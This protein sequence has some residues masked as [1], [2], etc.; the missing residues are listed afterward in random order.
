M[1]AVSSID[2]EEARLQLS[3][4]FLRWWDQAELIDRLRIENKPTTAAEQLLAVMQRTIGHLRRQ[5]GLLT[6]LAG[7]RKR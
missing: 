2:L 1:S 5:V 6:K 4:A 7:Q 3:E